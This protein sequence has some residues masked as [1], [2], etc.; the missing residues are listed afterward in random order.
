MPAVAQHLG[1]LTH[2]KAWEAVR[3]GNH[4]RGV[5]TYFHD[6]DRD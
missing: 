4:W 6:G 1:M 3:N 2:L 5:E